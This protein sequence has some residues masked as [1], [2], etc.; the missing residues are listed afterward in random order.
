[1]A[2]K[3]TNNET[4]LLTLILDKLGK[5][6]DLEKRIMAL[7]KDKLSTVNLVEDNKKAVFH[8]LTQREQEEIERRQKVEPLLDK[9]AS[10]VIECFAKN[11]PKRRGA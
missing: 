8:S 3:N 11:P 9:T 6:D 4:V 1:M 10:T 5:L 2:K 7:E